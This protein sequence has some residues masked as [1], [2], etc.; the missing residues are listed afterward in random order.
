MLT[1]LHQSYHQVRCL[2]RKTNDLSFGL[3]YIETK[4]DVCWRRSCFS[5][6]DYISCTLWF[7]M[8]PTR[9]GK[10]GKMRKLFQSGKSQGILNI[11]EKSG[12]FT[13][14][15]GKMREFYSKYWKKK[16]WRN[17]SQFYFIF[18]CDFLTL[19]PMHTWYCVFYINITRYLNQLNWGYLYENINNFQILVQ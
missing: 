10:P 14:N 17:F 7:Y 19:S 1:F 8:V 5:L 15:T 11:P 2:L 16:K 13:Q 9:T 18:F 6:L 4:K 3:L 12:N